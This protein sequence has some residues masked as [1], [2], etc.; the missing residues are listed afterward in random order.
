[1][2]KRGGSLDEAR[3]SGLGEE[4]IFLVGTGYGWVAGEVVS[5][6]GV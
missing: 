4:L 1:M 2:R 5:V 6:D 3:V